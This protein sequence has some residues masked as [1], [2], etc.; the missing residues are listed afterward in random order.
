MGSR[1]VPMR[2]ATSAGY[3][4]PDKP[5]AKLAS[6][7][8]VSLNKSHPGTQTNS[9]KEKKSWGDAVQKDHVWREFV[10]AERRGLKQWHEN[11]SFLK[12]YDSLG[13]KKEV[14]ELPEQLPMFSEDVPNTTNQNIGNR[15]N[16]DLGKRLIRMD[17]SLT[18]GNQ[19]K[20]LG[21]DFLPC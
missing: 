17:F 14:E 10:E 3:R 2:R 8:S 11:W 13:N 19:K 12:E 18:S 21:A 16:T 15:I 9:D 20:K 7:S 5:A 1:Q 6:H 4:M